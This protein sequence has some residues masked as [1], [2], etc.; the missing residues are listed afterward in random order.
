MGILRASY[1][2]IAGIA[3][4]VTTLS[5]QYRSCVDDVYK[6]I[7][8]LNEV[9]KGSDN[10][11]FVDKVRSYQKL[12]NDLGVEIENYATRLNKTAEVLQ[13]SQEEI[14]NLAGRL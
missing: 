6:T 10:V 12:L 7:D 1:A 3:G 5:S 13:Q 11:Q 4:R 14:K 8:S 9:W 2:E